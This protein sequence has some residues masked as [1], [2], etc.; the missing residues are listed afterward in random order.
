MILTEAA[1]WAVTVVAIA[2]VILN[3][4]RDRRCFNLWIFSNTV[5]A[6]LHASVRMYALT[7][8]DTVFLVLAVVG[9]RAWGKVKA[10][11]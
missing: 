6:A 4:R 2:G 11:T 3:N 9:L 10:Q 5:S 1:G 7:F 8:R